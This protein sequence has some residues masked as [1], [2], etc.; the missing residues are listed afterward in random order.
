MVILDSDVSNEFTQRRWTVSETEK[1][2]E[3]MQKL[4]INRWK[5]R[6]QLQ[7]QVFLCP[8]FKNMIESWSDHSMGVIWV[9]HSGGTMIQSILF[10]RRWEAG[11]KG[12]LNWTGMSRT[13]WKETQTSWGRKFAPSHDNWHSRDTCED[14][15][16]DSQ[17]K[18]KGQFPEE[19][20]NICVRSF[21]K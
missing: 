16:G 21:F 19:R 7:K 5:S 4:Q 6:R 3:K 13:G 11:V 20:F 9:C 14:Y 15:L 1:S 17:K 12:W 10:S 2:G 8:N 18:S